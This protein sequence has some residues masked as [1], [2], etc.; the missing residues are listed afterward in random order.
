MD[1]ARQHLNGEPDR[2]RNRLQL[3]PGNLD[4]YVALARAEVLLGHK[5]E[6]LDALKQAESHR[7]AGDRL[8]ETEIRRTHCFVLAWSGDREAA[9]G[10]IAALMRSPGGF[11]SHSS[12][13]SAYFAPLHG[14]PAFEAMLNDP[15]NNAPL[16]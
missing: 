11:T 4:L 15:A 12:R 3:Q 10:E 13:V 1:E 9:L 8:D 6:A 14:D 5:E 7:P 16:F 2:L